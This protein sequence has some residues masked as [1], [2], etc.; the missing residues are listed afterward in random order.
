[1][2]TARAKGGAHSTPWIDAWFDPVADMRAYDN[3]MCLADTDGKGESRLIV[4][5]CARARAGW[6]RPARFSRASVS[7]RPLTAAV[8]AQPTSAASLRCT[9]APTAN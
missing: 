4:G 7:A 5:A 8:R 1:M 9:A 3:Q 2:A 6:R